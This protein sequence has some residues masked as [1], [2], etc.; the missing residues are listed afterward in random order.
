[1]YVANV[2]PSFTSVALDGIVLDAAQPNDVAQDT[3]VTLTATWPDTAVEHFLYYEPTSQT[4][5]T[6]RESMRLSWFATGGELAVDAGA[7]GE[8]D[9]STAVATTWHTPASPGPAWLWLVLRD[10]R[11]GLTTAGYPITVR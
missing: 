4:L 7:V 3:E 11:G 5:I 8:T 2:N 1:M 9:G 10:S 6:R